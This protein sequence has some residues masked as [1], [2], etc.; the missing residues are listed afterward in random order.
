MDAFPAF[1]P[2]A[3]RTVV[4]AGA[5]EAAQAK[6][7][8]FAGSPATIRRLEGAAA[9]DPGGYAGAALAFIASDDDA[10][11]E[12][13][14]GAARA[15]HVPVNAVDRPALCDFTTPSVID[16]GAVVAAIGTGGASP[17]LATLLRHDIEARVPAG[18]GKVAALFASLQ[19]EV[20]AALPQAHRRRAFLRMALAGP[21]ARAAMAGDQAL[22]IGLLREALARDNPGAGVVQFIDARGPV[23]RLTL[24]AAHALAAADLLVCDEGVDDAVLDLARRDAERLGPRTVAELAGRV[25]EGLRVARLIVCP[26]WRAEQAAL[27]AAGVETEVLPIAG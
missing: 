22:A 4:I 6:L 12:A 3:G 24:A 5:G 23:D 19:D 18:A 20:R 8:L 1:F 15:A 13:A 2:L 16:R 25:G 9:L 21:A 17:M 7:R 11:A 27:D 14:A 26:G 10:F